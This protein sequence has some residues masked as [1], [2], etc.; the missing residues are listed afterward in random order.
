MKWFRNLFDRSARSE[1][2]E[3]EFVNRRGG[4][5]VEAAMVVDMDRLRPI[6]EESLTIGGW[7]IAVRLANASVLAVESGTNLSTVSLRAAAGVLSDVYQ[8]DL[9]G[10]ALSLDE[11]CALLKEKMEEALVKGYLDGQR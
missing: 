11:V 5:Y 7:P 4:E 6:I 2:T 8:V 9:R 1:T 3:K 10:D